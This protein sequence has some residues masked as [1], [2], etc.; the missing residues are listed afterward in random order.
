[1]SFMTLQCALFDFPWGYFYTF[2]EKGPV[3]GRRPSVSK[4]IIHKH[5]G[6]VSLVEQYLYKRCNFLKV[7]FFQKDL[8]VSLDSPKKQTNEFVFCTQTAFRDAKRR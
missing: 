4:V 3:K 6:E 8:L 2:Y 5:R 7:S 1:M